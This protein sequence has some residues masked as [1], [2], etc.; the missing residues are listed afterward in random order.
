MEKGFSIKVLDHG[1]VTYIDK[2]GEDSS[3]IE[4]ARQ[5]TGKGFLGWGPN[6][7]EHCGALELGYDGMGAFTYGPCTCEPKPGD[8]KLLRYL[9]TNRHTSPFEQCCLAI[10]VQAPIM[11]FREWH[12]HR[13]QS[14]NEF[15]A[16]YAKMPDLHYMPTV[17]RIKL[18]SNTNK[19]AQGIAPLADDEAVEKWLQRAEQLQ[20]AVYS[21]YEQGLDLGI[22]KEVARMNTP[23][24]RYSRM[25]AS[26]NLLNWFK[27]LDLRMDVNAQWEIR[28]CANAVGTIVETL[29]PKSWELFNE[30]RRR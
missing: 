28:Q 14:Y 5:S 20:K 8:E 9:W 4:A 2:M 1:F 22:A 15:S 24:S 25:V 27:F 7:E 13:T 26:A 29:F 19:Q 6:H 12:R 18:T 21:H 3:I 10:G 17:D 11:V 16:R 30:T 23:V